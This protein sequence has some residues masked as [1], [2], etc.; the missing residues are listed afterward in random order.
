MAV[1]PDSQGLLPDPEIDERLSGLEGWTREGD[2][3][4]AIKSRADDR[5]KPGDVLVFAGAEEGIFCLV[6]VL[7]VD[8]LQ[9]A[10]HHVDAA[11][12]GLD[13]KEDLNG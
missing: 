10:G 9:R 5:I 13:T 7:L 11:A 1:P 3:I 12:D 4:A 2:A 8:A 6:N